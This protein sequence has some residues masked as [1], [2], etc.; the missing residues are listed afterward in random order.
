MCFLVDSNISARRWMAAGRLL[1]PTLLATSVVMF[2]AGIA[3][4]ES[5]TSMGGGSAPNPTPPISVLVGHSAA[6]LAPS[7]APISALQVAGQ[8]RWLWSLRTRGG[9]PVSYGSTDD[10]GFTRLDLAAPVMLLDVPEAGV[11]GLPIGRG[12]GLVIAPGL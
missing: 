2:A 11:F 10:H 3:A 7:Q 4:R 5:A 1:F 9:L 8:R 12:I 6:T